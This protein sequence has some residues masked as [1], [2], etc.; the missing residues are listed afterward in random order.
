MTTTKKDVNLFFT[1]DENYI[2]FLSV[3]LES[4]RA[5]ASK[6][7]NY[8]IKILHTNTIKFVTQELMLKEYY[9]DNFELEFV[10][11]T[12]QVKPI[13]SSLHTRDY[14][15]KSTYYRLF[16]PTLYP[17]LD[18]ALYLD[19]DIVVLGDISELYNVDLGENLLGAVHDQAVQNTPEFQEYV[20]NRIGVKN[21][22]DYFNAGVLLMNLAKLR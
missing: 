22:E 3:T 12:N 11:I 4:I 1:C 10:D 20:L 15:S 16:I 5:N 2:P 7:F 8:V 6:N 17:E 13:F 18:K 21:Q 14:Y 19:S 9:H